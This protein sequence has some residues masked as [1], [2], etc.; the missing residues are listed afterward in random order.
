M[1][2]ANDAYLEGRVLSADPLELVRLLYQA[3]LGA[4]AEARRFLADGK[5]AERSREISRATATLIELTAALDRQRGGE[6]G[7]RLAALYEYMVHRLLDANM[8]QSDE[9]LAEVSSLLATLAEGWAGIRQPAE[10]ETVEANLWTAPEAVAACA[11]Q[12]WTL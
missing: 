11:S 10:P 2:R 4:V 6:I 8:T 9:P 3:A 1:N 5:I 12:A 7:S